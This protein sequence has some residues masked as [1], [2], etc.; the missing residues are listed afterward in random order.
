MGG[1]TAGVLYGFIYIGYCLW[2]AKRHNIPRGL[3]STFREKLTAAKRASWALGVPVIILGGIYGGV[4]TPTEASGVSAIYA[5]LVSMFVYRDMDL[6][7]LWK[8]CIDSVKSCAQV[9][10]L[11]SAAS[12]FS[13]VLTVGQIPQ[14][15]AQFI[16]NANPSPALFL[17]SVNILFLIA[18]MFVDG[19]SA[20]IILAPLLYPVAQY[21]GIDL[22]HFG[23]V[24]V[25]NVA[26]GMFTP[27]FGLNLFVAQPVTG[28]DMKTIIRSSLPFVA[29]SL[30]AL[31][32]I[33]Y[34]PQIS[35]ML[36]RLF[37][38]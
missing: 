4:F 30:I 10:I 7:L 13:W 34:I 35:L 22:I 19:S 23:V 8:S 36:P 38:G 28:N 15:L 14:S 21:L 9:M 5:L 24:L 3:K 17:L 12:I 33:T 20:T 26:I 16:I 27:P 37:Y 1:L 6:K 25:A 32:I 18:G 29:I 31:V 2:Y 11:L